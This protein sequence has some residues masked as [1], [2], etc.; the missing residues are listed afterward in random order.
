MTDAD[1]K[2]L[3][4]RTAEAAVEK[5]LLRLGIQPVQARLI[6]LLA[7]RR[8]NSDQKIEKL[9]RPCVNGPWIAFERRQ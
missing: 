1:I 6:H 9:R 2:D 4:E 8:R 5:V 3:A 7:I